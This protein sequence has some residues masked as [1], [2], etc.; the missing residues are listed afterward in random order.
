MEIWDLY[1]KNENNTGKEW[2][3]SDLESIP[4]GFY[5]LVCEILVRHVDGD[6]LLMKRD[7]SKKLGPGHWE[8]TSG[9]SALKGESALSCAQRE[10]LEETGIKSDNF[11]EIGYSIEDDKHGIYHSYL[12][13][14]NC[15]KDNVKLQLGETINYKWISKDE[16]IEFM[17]TDQMG[18]DQ[19]ERY[20]AY[21]NSLMNI[22]A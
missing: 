2:L 14:V 19:K 8:A 20:T 13:T 7:F 10:L 17:K 18:A 9:G 4:D 5:H 6:F 12:T 1:D 11:K 15:A 21:V 16:F 22:A 3:R